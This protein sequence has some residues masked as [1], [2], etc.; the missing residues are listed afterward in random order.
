M[1]G[2]GIKIIKYDMGEWDKKCFYA[3]DRFFEWFDFLFVVLLSYYF[4]LKES[5]YL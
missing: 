5:D 3:S 1:R 4:L 2:N